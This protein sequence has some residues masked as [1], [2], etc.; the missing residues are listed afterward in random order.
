MTGVWLKKTSDEVSIP[1]GGRLL[2]GFYGAVGV[3]ILLGYEG[4]G[5]SDNAFS[6]PIKD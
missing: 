4:C 5:K 2:Q 6:P 3:G 1:A